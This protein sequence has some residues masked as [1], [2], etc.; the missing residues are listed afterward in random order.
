MKM[1]IPQFKSE[2]AERLYWERHSSANK[3]D[4]DKAVKNPAFP[5][6]KPSN[7]TISIRLPESLL[8]DLKRL[9]SKQDVPY[10]SLLKIYLSEKV[11]EKTK[12]AS[13]R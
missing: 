2:Q 5:E 13:R 10:Q 4:W 9:A 3:V 6:L 8:R 7:K 11:S 12:E 1:K